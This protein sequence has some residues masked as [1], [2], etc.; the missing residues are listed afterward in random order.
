MF[1]LSNLAHVRTVADER[2]QPEL[3]AMFYWALNVRPSL[4]KEDPPVDWYHI[5]I[6]YFKCVLSLRARDRRASRS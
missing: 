2:R 6:G 3:P 1:A 4:V 5:A